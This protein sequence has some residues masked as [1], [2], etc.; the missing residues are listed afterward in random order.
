MIN[1]LND[2]YHDAQD[3]KIVLTKFLDLAQISQIKALNKERLKVYFEGGFENAERLRAIIQLE[4]YEEPTFDDFKISIYC[5]EYNPRHCP[6]HHR[7]VLGTIMSLGIERS[8]FGD[9]N[10][11]DNKIFIFVTREIEKYLVSNLIE[12]N[13][14]NVKF[15]KI[16]SFENFNQK[17]DIIKTINVASLRLDAVIARTLNISRAKAVEMIEN[18]MVAINHIICE[19]ITKK[20]NLNEI[21]SVRKFGR[22]TILDNI[23]TTKKDRLSIKVGVK[24]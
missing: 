22:I 1:R 11:V 15:Q 19:N 4:N 14:Q 17:G 8:T 9:I 16:D 12:I 23:K 2:Y 18:K 10:I 20:C 7:N 3:G 21:I 5:A 24:H 13:H 6:I